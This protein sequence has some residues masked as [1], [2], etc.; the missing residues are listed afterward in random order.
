MLPVMTNPYS[1]I[2]KYFFFQK[3]LQ[4]QVLFLKRFYFKIQK[5][6]LFQNSEIQNSKFRNLKFYFFSP[7]FLKYDIPIMTQDIKTLVDTKYRCTRN[8][9]IINTS[10]RNLKTHSTNIKIR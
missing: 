4:I 3:L 7:L 10:C 5:K 6:I 2:Q 1:N 8:A 9:H